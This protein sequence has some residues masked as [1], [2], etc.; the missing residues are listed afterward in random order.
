MPFLVAV[1][2]RPAARIPVA[3]LTR[4]AAPIPAVVHG[5]SGRGKEWST[6]RSVPR[7]VGSSVCGWGSTC[8]R[9]IRY[10][11]GEYKVDIRLKGNGWIEVKYDN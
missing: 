8:S 10:D 5:R 7:S 2:I 11:F 9:R 6:S 1:L 3:V 4:L